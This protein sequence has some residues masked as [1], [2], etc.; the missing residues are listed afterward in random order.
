MP[1]VSA[2]TLCSLAFKRWM[3]A[4]H[5]VRPDFDE[6]EPFPENKNWL[7]EERMSR[8]FTLTDEAVPLNEEVTR[9]GV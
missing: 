4:S 2:L 6:K 5:C 3:S 8:L 9:N 7:S 1:F